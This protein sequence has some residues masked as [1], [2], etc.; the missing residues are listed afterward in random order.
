MKIGTKA[1]EK[2]SPYTRYVPE[3]KAASSKKHYE[4][5]G[6]DSSYVTIQPVNMHCQP[7]QG[8]KG[9][10]D[11]LDKKLEGINHRFGDC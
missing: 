9:S 2:C 6:M 7:T 11:Y 3:D 8:E 1:P 4:E 10:S 5:M